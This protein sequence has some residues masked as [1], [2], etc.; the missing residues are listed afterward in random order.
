MLPE[1]ILGEF[2]LPT[3]GLMAVIGFLAAIFVATT[4]SN[5]CGMPKMDIVFAAIYCAVGVIIGA[6][7]LYF[8]TVLPN[9]IKHIELLSTS[10]TAVLLYAFSGFVFYGGLIGGAF[11]IWVY[12]KQFHLSISPL[13]NI[14]AVA[15]P[16]FHG[17]G[18][19]GCLLGGCC[20]GKEYHGAFAVTF[21]DNTGI[22]GLAGVERFPTQLT[23]AIFNFVLFILIYI[24][25]KKG[26]PRS[27]QALG[28][29]LI[30]Y[31]IERFLLEFMRGDSVRGFF[32]PF[33]TSQWISLTL[34]P[35]GLYLTFRKEKVDE[36]VD[37]DTL[38]D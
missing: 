18:R 27:G 7:L 20:Y 29:Y 4:L 22:K 17:F 35:L 10:P 34:L 6:K 12:C 19:L 31:P 24:F 5:K 32:G 8:I 16:L 3:Y 21:P 36:A 13:M 38:D 9:I 33:S 15:V 14:M 25:V 26:K 28:I 37:V 11:G 2:S 30:A 23:E 1:I